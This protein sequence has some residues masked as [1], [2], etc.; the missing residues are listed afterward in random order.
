MLGTPSP[1]HSLS[2]TVCLCLLVCVCLSL[3][4]SVSLSLSVCLN[5]ICL[6]LS[7]SL[8]LSLPLSLSLCVCFFSDFVYTRCFFAGS[9][10]MPTW[11]AS[12]VTGFAKQSWRSRPCH[13]TDGAL[14]KRLGPARLV[15]MRTPSRIPPMTASPHPTSWALPSKAVTDGAPQKRLGP[16]LLLST[17]PPE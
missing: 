12:P 13:R 11:S 7:L 17:R 9:V 16:A 10:Q 5:T 15:S 6:S 4:F 14:Q 2:V 8:S 1:L 3:S